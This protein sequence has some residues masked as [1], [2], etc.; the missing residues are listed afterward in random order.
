[1]LWIYLIILQVLFFAGLLYFLR[2]VLTRNISKATGRLQALSKDFVTKEEEAKQVL[3][4]AQKESKGILAKETQEAQEKKR[5]IIKEAN[6]QGER[7][8]KEA[9]QKGTEI[10]EMAQKNADFIQKELDRRIDER[11]KEKVQDLVQ[12]SIPKDFLMDVH[13]KWVHEADKGAFNLKHLKIPD[14]VKEAKIASAFPLSDK[15]KRDL[16]DKLKKKI[17]NAVS[18]KIEV[19]PALIAGFVINIGSVVID[20]SLKYKIQKSLQE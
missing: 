2:Y 6:E 8:L 5:Q 9:N 16:E 20:A 19:E 14:K 11:A 15:Q 3:L 12:N 1:M 4:T 18:V 17:G 10:A 13:Q 7:I